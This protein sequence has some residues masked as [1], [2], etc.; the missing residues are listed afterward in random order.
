MGRG[1]G[2]GMLSQGPSSVTNI[3][4]QEEERGAYIEREKRNSDSSHKKRGTTRVKHPGKGG[5]LI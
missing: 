3:V 2:Q 1:S 4:R 5:D